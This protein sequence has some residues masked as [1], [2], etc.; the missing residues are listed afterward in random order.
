VE[1]MKIG[2]M[3]PYLFPYLGY[4]QL[5]QTSDKF[6][7]HDDVQYIRQGWINRNQ[8]ILH[9][10]AFLF[11][12]SVKHD[13]YSKK[14]NERFYAQGFDAEAKKFLRNIDQSY[15]KAPYF[16]EVRAMLA[17]ILATPE[18]NVA[19]LNTMSI[20]KICEYLGIGAEILVSSELDFDKSLA[21]EER[22]IAINQSL[23]STH[24]I[25]PI[26]GVE[27]Y[28]LERFEEK[29]LQL[30]FL[31]PVLRPYK[32]SSQE[33]LPS[34]SIIDVMMNC[35]K[36]ELCEMLGEFELIRTMSKSSARVI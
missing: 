5:I 4:F 24:Y 28:S 31:K 25:N 26:G 19:K 32:Q 6:V 12:F 35:S 7:V 33:F 11:V 27:L 23:G 2:L 17:A 10:R 34:L 13:D 18:R 29:G 21:A 30:S 36:A 9:N 16:A 22:V 3:Q 15:S 1:M 8:I 20:R 14:I